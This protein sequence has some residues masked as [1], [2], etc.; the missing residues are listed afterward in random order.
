MESAKL[1]DILGNANRRKIIKLL[2]S[3]PCY[4]SEISD[5]VGVGP[6]AVLQ[7]LDL[8][9][10][11]GLI[12]GYT[13]GDRRKYYHITE[14]F[15]LEVFV[16]P[17]SCIIETSTVT[18]QPSS[19]QY[20]VLPNTSADRSKS[21]EE[22]KTLNKHLFKLE[23]KRRQLANEQRKIEGKMTDIMAK[24]IDWVYAAVQDN[25]KAEIILTILKEP[26]D[27]HSLSMNL[28]LPEY[29][30]EEHIKSLIDNNILIEREQNNRQILSLI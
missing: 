4:V 10:Q 19:D 22:L 1:L 26:Q 28:R 16:S 30:M 17:Y 18:Q 21:I 13:K 12:S 23:S 15:K 14:N 7:H 9:E 2:A 6:K 29:F 5:R 27:R 25:V 3:K 8:L 20:G 24:C 11:I